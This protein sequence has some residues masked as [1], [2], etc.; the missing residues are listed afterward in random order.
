MTPLGLLGTSGEPLVTSPG[1]TFQP[2]EIV[3]GG[4]KS[5]ASQF[6]NNKPG[7]P[8]QLAAEGRL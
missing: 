1:L 7:G 6:L 5:R 8:G 4:K 3:A 2:C